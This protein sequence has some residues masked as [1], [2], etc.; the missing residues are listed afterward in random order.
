MGLF[1]S[2]PDPSS[3]RTGPGP[4]AAGRQGPEQFEP[5]NPL[6]AALP[7]T[8]GPPVPLQLRMIPPTGPGPWLPGSMRLNPGSVIW[9]PE[10]GVRAV[11]VELASA[12]MAGAARVRVGKN[13]SDVV[14]LETAI[15]MVQIDTDPQLWALVLEEVGEMAARQNQQGGTPPWQPNQ[16]WQPN[17][18]W[19]PD[20]PSPPGS[21]WPQ[22]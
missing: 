6:T 18:P 22:G 20:P 10:A 9:V 17:L 19:Q 1:R 5:F 14:E 2:R 12:P 8:A 3:G 7:P 4:N 11:P 13:W 21:P 16:P 15:G